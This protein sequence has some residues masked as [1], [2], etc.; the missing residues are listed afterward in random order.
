ML[1]WLVYTEHVGLRKKFFK[2]LRPLVFTLILALVSALIFKLIE[3]LRH[4]ATH[5]APGW[6]TPD[7]DRRLLGYAAQ[8]VQENVRGPLGLA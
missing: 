1:R 8:G 6:K 4:S 3:E 5:V 2:E 7:E